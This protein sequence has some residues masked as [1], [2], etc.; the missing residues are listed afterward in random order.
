MAT[1][2]QQTQRNT[3]IIQ[4]V[5]GAKYAEAAAAINGLLDAVAKDHS[6]Q[7]LIAQIRPGGHACGPN[8]FGRLHSLALSLTAWSSSAPTKK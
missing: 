6:N 5:Y 8:T 1:V 7:K 4:R 2:E 3:E